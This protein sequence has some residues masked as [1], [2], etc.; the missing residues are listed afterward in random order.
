MLNIQQ[1]AEFS[2]FKT[3]RHLRDHGAGPDRLDTKATT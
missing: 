3:V 2:A 1:S